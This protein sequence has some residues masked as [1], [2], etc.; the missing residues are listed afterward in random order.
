MH[1]FPS[2]DC[3][4][5][6]VGGGA[7][8]L[9]MAYKLLVKKKERGVCVF[10][11]ENRTGGRILDHTFKEAPDIHVGKLPGFK[12]T[13]GRFY[14]EDKRRDLTFDVSLDVLFKINLIDEFE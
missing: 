12:D 6:I 10:E 7:A 11:S 9:Y 3:D 4:V 13:F 5:G 8:G 1:L 14:N 2:I